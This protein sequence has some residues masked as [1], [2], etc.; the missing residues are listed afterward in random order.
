MSFRK[1]D[2]EIRITVAELNNTPFET[3]VVAKSEISIESCV[4]SVE[5]NN[6]VKNFTITRYAL[7]D[8]LKAYFA[9]VKPGA[10]ILIQKRIGY[11]LEG[12]TKLPSV[13]YTVV[14][15]HEK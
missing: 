1:A 7:P 11:G 13:T 15:K 9:T 2:G 8:E 6:E 14:E 10:K 5:I 12:K 4:V 3:L